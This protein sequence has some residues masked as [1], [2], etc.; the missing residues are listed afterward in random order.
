MSDLLLFPESQ[1]PRLAVRHFAAN[2]RGRDWVV[3]DLHG[4][5]DLLMA[6]LDLIGFDNKVDRVFC[7][8]D[9]V[10][11]GPRCLEILRLT[12]EPW[13]FSLRGNHEQACIDL[14]RKSFS[15]LGRMSPVDLAHAAENLGAGWLLPL[16]SAQQSEVM[17]LI[18]PLP[19]AFT[20][21]S[22]HGTVGMVH[23]E[24]PPWLKWAD[25]CSILKSPKKN[26]EV[27]DAAI[28]SRE[29]PQMLAS[30]KVS[31]REVEASLPPVD[32]IGCV[33]HGHVVM[34][35]PFRKDN[36]FYLDTGACR[37]AT[38]DWCALTLVELG[39]GM[40]TFDRESRAP[41]QKGLRVITE[42]PI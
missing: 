19:L 41:H 17:R 31:D 28:C 34:K 8:G 40:V 37:A 5:Y 12:A 30:N 3:P 15:R 10:D 16:S 32:G 20:V 7:L 42:S 35:W 25:F 2:H 21:A 39:V 22:E 27:C 33:Y 18:A 11:R 13:F 6:G 14:H 38:K 1:W 4:S 29:I 36:R 26:L 23:A 24:I 9:M